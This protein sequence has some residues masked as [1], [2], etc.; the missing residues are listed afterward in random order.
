MTAVVNSILLFIAF[1]LLLTIGIF[2]IITARNLAGITDRSVQ[3]NY[4]YNLTIVSSVLSIVGATAIL[5]A[6]IVYLAKGSG[7]KLTFIFFMVLI[8]LLLIF[9]ITILSSISAAFINVDDN[10]NKSSAYKNIIISTLISVFG[11]IIILVLLILSDRSAENSKI[12]DTI[13]KGK[14]GL[15]NNISDL[16]KKIGIKPK[17]AELLEDN[18]ELLAV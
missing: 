5:V 12:A 1:G 16:F 14:G 13:T 15:K 10:V 8:T 9:I 11:F 6:I 4:A 18:P 3:L 2:N 7:N 17:E